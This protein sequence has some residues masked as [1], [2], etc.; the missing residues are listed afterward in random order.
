MKNKPKVKKPGAQPG[1]KNAER[2]GFYSKQFT[3]DESKRLA[4]ADRLSVEDEIDLIRVSIDRLSKE[5]SF[6]EKTLTDSNGNATR[7][8]HY[9]AQLNTLSIMTQA[10]STLIRTHYLTKGKGGHI[11]SS[12]ME[13]LEELRLEMGL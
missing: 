3:A 1:N 2:H 12:I 5:L 6:D 11:E 8:S 9:L 7:D 13:A 4:L 10:I